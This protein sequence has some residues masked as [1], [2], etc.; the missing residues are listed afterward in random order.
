MEGNGEDAATE[1]PGE[2]TCENNER[3]R[4]EKGSSVSEVANNDGG[5][6]VSNGI[7]DN[8]G[9]N[10]KTKKPSYKAVL[11]ED[12]MPNYLATALFDNRFDNFVI[13]KGSN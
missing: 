3:A 10:R 6:R 11:T 1:L 12:S 7:M 4:G 9:P 5:E 2:P 13:V 8:C